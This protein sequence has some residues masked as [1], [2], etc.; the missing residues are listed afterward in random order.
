MGV[1]GAG[2]GDH[3]GARDR[4][5]RLVARALVPCL[6]PALTGHSVG[7]ANYDALLDDPDL[8][9]AVGHTLLF[10]G[11]FVPLSL[12]LGL[13]LAIALN[14]RIRL[15]GFYRTAILLPFIASTAVQGVLFSYIFDQ[16]FGVANASST[17]WGSRGRGSW[18]TRTRRC[19]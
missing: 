17:S 4:P 7:F 9:S 10:T 13:L 18:A 12:V 15:I 1:R 11:L 6:G 19:W 16:R 3:R 14:R 5:D 2:G 8:R